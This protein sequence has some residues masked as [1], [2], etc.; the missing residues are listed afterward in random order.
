M[1]TTDGTSLKDDRMG[2]DQPVHLLVGTP[3]RILDFAERGIA[4]LKDCSM[5]IMDEADKLLSP[6]FQPFVQQLIH[7]M[8]ENRQILMFSATCPVTVKDFIDRFLHNPYV[9]D[10]TNELPLKGR[11]QYY[12]FVEDIQKVDYVETLLSKLMI[13]QSIIFCNSVNRVEYLAK[14]FKEFGYPCFYI[15]AK[16]PQDH[17]NRVLH[18]FRNLACRTLVCTDLVMKRIDIQDVNVVINFDIP[19]NSET[20]LQRVGR[21]GRFGHQDFLVMNL[22]TYEDRFDL[23]RIEKELRTEIKQIQPHYF[24]P[25]IGGECNRDD[26]FKSSVELGEC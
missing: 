22:I 2:L 15:H 17:C 3:G 16:M 12:T 24:K 10:M 5:L 7:F 4:I 18:D 9:I 11:T 14:K 6:E 23:C 13:N 21:F 1:V 25:F 8:P 26:L 19:K 20:Y